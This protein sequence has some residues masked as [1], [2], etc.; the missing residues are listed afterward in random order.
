MSTQA[1]TQIAWARSEEARIRNLSTITVLEADLA[2]RQA[3]LYETHLHRNA[4]ARLKGALP[5]LY[6]IWEA[7]PD[8]EPADKI[9]AAGFQLA[10]LGLIDGDL[11]VLA[12]VPR[13]DPH[14]FADDDPD[15]AK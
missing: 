10:D 2:S 9:T 11:E 4:V 6:E 8:L 14:G 12:T 13:A 5:A 1:L 7:H 15:V 3:V